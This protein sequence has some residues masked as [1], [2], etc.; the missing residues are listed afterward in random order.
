MTYNLLN[1]NIQISPSALH[2]IERCLSPM[3]RSPLDEVDDSE[4]INILQPDHR[5]GE[6]LK[7]RKAA[8]WKKNLTSNSN[9]N[10]TTRD[11][12][13]IENAVD[14]IDAAMNICS[15]EANKDKSSGSQKPSAMN[16]EGIS[17][18]AV[19]EGVNKPTT[20][21]LYPIIE[22][23]TEEEDAEIVH[24]LRPPNN[25]RATD[26]VSKPKDASNSTNV[27]IYSNRK[28]KR[29]SPTLS[30]T[31]KHNSSSPLLFGNL[32]SP[33]PPSGL[34]IRG[35]FVSSM[36]VLISLIHFE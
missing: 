25:N 12:V 30:M 23:V 22:H 31:N 16:T 3:I 34:S 19:F 24:I 2:Y 20:N 32:K 29:R 14:T 27:S 26:I 5:G 17:A 7:G 36:M 18:D 21:A 13:D 35:E 33:L 8:M 10:S 6:K 1:S 28:S 11:V 4:I 9:V 15:I